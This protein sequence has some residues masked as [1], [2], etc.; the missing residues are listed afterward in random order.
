MHP[1][2]KNSREDHFTDICFIGKTN[3]KHYPYKKPPKKISR[4]PPEHSDAGTNEKRMSMLWHKTSRMP[5]SND[6]YY[7]I[8][9]EIR[10]NKY[11]NINRSS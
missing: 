6:Q 7:K 10:Q 4:N 1:G 8:D 3:L 9:C 11:W 2:A 5:Q